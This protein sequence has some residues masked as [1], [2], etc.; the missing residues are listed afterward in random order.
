MTSRRTAPVAAACCCCRLRAINDVDAATPRNDY[1]G[2][3]ASASQSLSQFAAY[4]PTVILWDTPD[5]ISYRALRSRSVLSSLSCCRTARS[6]GV[7]W[8]TQ[9]SG[10]VAE[11]AG[12]MPPLWILTRQRFLFQNT[13]FC[14]VINLVR[15]WGEIE[16]LS[17]YNSLCCNCPVAYRKMAISCLSL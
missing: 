11:Q 5:R 12:D 6:T 16:F 7:G 3:S 10:V 13:K 1:Y 4:V 17:I 8:R 9:S 15:F 2:E 14:G